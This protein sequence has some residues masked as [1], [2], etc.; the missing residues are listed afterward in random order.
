[1]QSKVLKRNRNYVKNKFAKYKQEYD[2]IF[3]FVTS[4][5][6][7]YSYPRYGKVITRSTLKKTITQLLKTAVE[8]LPETAVSCQIT[9]SQQKK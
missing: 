1:M 8:I 2:Q 3:I 9:D 6:L 5:K 7:K 4:K